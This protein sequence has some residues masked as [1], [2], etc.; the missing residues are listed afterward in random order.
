MT[1]Q[2]SGYSHVAICVKDVPVAQRFY[3]ET[4]G[5]PELPRPNFDFPGAWYQV[6][7]LQLHLMQRDRAPTVEQG[8]GPHIALHVSTEQFPSTVE[9]LRA[10]GTPITREPAQRESDGVWAAFCTDPDGNLIEI[11]DMGPLA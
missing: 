6:G 8:V 1:V 2:I 7:A 5:L 9:A 11:T 3:G 10:A 4:L